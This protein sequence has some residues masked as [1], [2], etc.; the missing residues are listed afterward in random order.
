MKK[1]KKKKIYKF[2]FTVFFLSFLVVYFSELT[3]YYEYQN[4]KKATLTQE[5]IRQF[6]KDVA[7]GK[8][9]DIN[10]YL[11]VEEKNYNNGLSELT[12]KKQK[13]HTLR[14]ILIFIG[15][16]AVCSIIILIIF[17]LIK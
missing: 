12:S 4:H 7:N 2:V 8:E 11:V 6:E 17:N 5:Q 14:N 3:G 16:L 15:I 13:K 1:D 10:E 9:V